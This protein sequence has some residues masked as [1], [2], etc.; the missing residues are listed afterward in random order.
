MG[1]AAKIGFQRADCDRIAS[2]RS[3]NVANVVS[4]IITKEI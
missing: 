3:E 4:G 1:S 2:E